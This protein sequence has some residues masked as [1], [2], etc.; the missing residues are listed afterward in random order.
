[1]NPSTPLP[2]YAARTV[3]ILSLLVLAADAAEAQA[4][5]GLDGG[6]V[7]V[8]VTFSAEDRARI[9]AYYEA[10]PRGGA[11]ALPPGIRKKVARGRPLPPGIAKRVA[12][13]PVRSVVSASS[14]YEV[15]E[16]GLDV[17]LVEAATGIIR[18]VIDNVLH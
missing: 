1:M 10:N 9:R 17:L 8:E 3:F 2:R 18:D 15:V 11:E 6:Q 5:K 7:A 16:V 12:P 4:R 13:E 14:E